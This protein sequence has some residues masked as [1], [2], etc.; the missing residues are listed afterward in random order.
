M[1][2]HELLKSITKKLLNNVNQISVCGVFTEANNP[3]KETDLSTLT[4]QEV[5]DKMNSHLTQEPSD[6]NSL[7]FLKYMVSFPV[8][9]CKRDVSPMLSLLIGFH[10]RLSFP[11]NSMITSKESKDSGLEKISYEDLAEIFGRSKATI[12][13]CVNKTEGLWKEFL[14]EMKQQEAI[15]A[16]AKAQLLAE[17]K[18]QLKTE[19]ETKEGTNE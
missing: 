14:E 17:R 18:E 8:S 3:I 10:Y 9:M 19:Q 11:E 6:V 7:V 16:E 5:L 2:E 12:S 4:T 1:D 15:D 13:D